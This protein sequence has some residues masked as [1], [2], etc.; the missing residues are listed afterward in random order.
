MAD[1]GLR[2][3]IPIDE[4][5]VIKRWQACRNGRDAVREKLV[6][7]RDGLLETRH[8]LDARLPAELLAGKRDVRPTLLGIVR[9]QRLVEDLRARAGQLDGQSSEF[10]DR[11]LVWIAEIDRPDELFRRSHETEEAVDEVVDVAEGAGLAS[12]SVDCDRIAAQRLDEEVGDDAPVVGLHA[13]AVGVEDAGDLDL[14]PVLPVVVEEE[15]LGAT[16]AFVVA[17]AEADR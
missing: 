5:G 12:V 1:V 16:L 17:G 7:I 11:E 15:R 13:W 4:M 14:H 9:R 6:E 3:A 10:R 8:E 2:V